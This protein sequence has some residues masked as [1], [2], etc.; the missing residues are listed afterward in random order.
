[1][2]FN[3][4][5]GQRYLNFQLGETSYGVLLDEVK[6]VIAVSRI[7]PLPGAEPY[8][9]GIIQVR[10]NII[11]I[12]DL[13]LKLNI[14]IKDQKENA[15]IVCERNHKMIGFVVDSISNVFSAEEASLSE[16]P[17]VNGKILS[18]FIKSIYRHN[19]TIVLII[20]PDHLMTEED[21]DRILKSIFQQNAA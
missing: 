12:M 4:T 10:E 11:P 18:Q 7:T 3:K 6:E 14:E 21:H 2:N 1:M 20:E 13:R 8:C 16:L 19:E 9:L 5:K 15:I 17:E